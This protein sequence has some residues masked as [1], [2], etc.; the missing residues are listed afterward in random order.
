MPACSQ[1]TA[2]CEAPPSWDPLVPFSQWKRQK[3]KPTVANRTVMLSRN[4]ALV[5]NLKLTVAFSHPL[6]GY[7]NFLSGL[8]YW[9]FDPVALKV[10]EG[11]PRNI[12]MDFFGCAAF[13]SK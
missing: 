1:W 10:L 8:Q 13:L 11:Y 12:G 6:T 4:R 5:K 9:K 7:A 3:K 2:V